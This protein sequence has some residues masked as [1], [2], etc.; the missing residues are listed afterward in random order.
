LIAIAAALTLLAYLA[1][2]L[3]W[4][5]YLIPVVLVAVGVAYYV[6]QVLPGQHHGQEKQVY[7]RL[8]HKAHGDKE[9]VARLIEHERRRSQ[10]ADRLKLL[11]DVLYYWERDSR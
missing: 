2:A 9:L 8:L 1:Y 11:Q 7:Q 4:G 3:A 10:G 6:T 5:I